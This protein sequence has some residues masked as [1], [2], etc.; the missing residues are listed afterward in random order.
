MKLEP[1]LTVAERRTLDKLLDII[2]NA[3][4]PLHTVIS[5]HRNLFSGSMGRHM[6]LQRE[7]PH[8]KRKRSHSAAR[9]DHPQ[10]RKRTSVARPPKPSA[11]N[12]ASEVSNSGPAPQPSTPAVEIAGLSDLVQQLEANILPADLPVASTAAPIL[13]LSSAP[14]HHDEPL[15]IHNRSVEE[16]QQLYHEVVD[17]LLSYKNGNLRPYSLKL[18]RCIKQKLWERLD[19]PTFT[20]TVGEDGRVHVDVSYGVG[21]NPPLYDVDISRE[22]KPVMPPKKR[23]GN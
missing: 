23:A 20:E 11:E 12:P 15:K 1:L 6:R 21:V 5:T 7:V 10:K 16:Y 19:R 9:G 4:P 14:L 3:S 2:D 17:D 22:P 8:L 18:G 13:Q